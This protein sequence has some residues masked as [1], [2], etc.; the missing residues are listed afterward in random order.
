VKPQVRGGSLTVV[1]KSDDGWDAV[2]PR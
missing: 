2:R 1:Q